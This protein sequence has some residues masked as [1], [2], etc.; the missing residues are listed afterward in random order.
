MR[1]YTHS[2][3]KK[4]IETSHWYSWNIFTGA[5]II[6]TATDDNYAATLILLPVNEFTI[7]LAIS[8]AS[9]ITL[10]RFL[11]FGKSISLLHHY[12]NQHR[13]L[14]MDQRMNPLAQSYLQMGRPY[15]CLAY[16]HPLSVEAL[17]WERPQ[18]L[19]EIAQ[20]LPRLLACGWSVNFGPHSPAALRGT[21]LN[22]ETLQPN[23]GIGSPGGMGSSRMS[24]SRSRGTQ[25]GR[26]GTAH[27]G[28]ASAQGAAGSARMD[29]YRSTNP[30]QV[31]SDIDS[32]DEG[33][34]ASD[35]YYSDG[36][37]GRL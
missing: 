19:Q 24:G 33:S 16:G 29:Y 8:Y 13:T 35:C 9:S 3:A 12:H 18:V 23:R 28:R 2:H 10:L 25:R 7:K 31:W 26:G 34:L 11:R 1:R 15:Q 27:R 30:R 37:G 6:M 22:L 4:K 36:A 32:D 20:D 5:A 14:I 21:L 17:S